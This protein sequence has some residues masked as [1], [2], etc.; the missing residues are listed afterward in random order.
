MLEQVGKKDEKTMIKMI[1][2]TNIVNEEPTCNNILLV[3][4]TT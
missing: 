1:K 3:E 2:A 4:R